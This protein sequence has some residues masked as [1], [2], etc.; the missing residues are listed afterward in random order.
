MDGSFTLMLHVKAGKTSVERK[1]KVEGRWEW[2]RKQ[3]R[4]CGRDRQ[5]GCREAMLVQFIQRGGRETSRAQKVTLDKQERRGSSKGRRKEVKEVERR[6][7]GRDEAD[8]QAM[9]DA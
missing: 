1:A 9:Q 2:F 6:G 4:C 7:E 8:A 5:R 3:E